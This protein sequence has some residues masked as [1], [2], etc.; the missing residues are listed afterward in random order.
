[1]SGQQQQA[2]LQSFDRQVSLQRIHEAHLGG[3]EEQG[4]RLGGRLGGG[5]GLGLGLGGQQRRGGR[6]GV[7]RRDLVLQRH[8]AGS[9]V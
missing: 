7:H 2:L 8:A 6:G 3:P 4:A 5:L 1:V 9:A